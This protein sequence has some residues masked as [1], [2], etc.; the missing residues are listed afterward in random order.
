MKVDDFN[1]AREKL[2][3]AFPFM[4]NTSEAYEIW[5]NSLLD[6][7]YRDVNKAVTDW[8]LEN[9]EPP[10]IAEIRYKTRSAERARLSVIDVHNIETCKC[11]KCQ[12]SGLII[13]IYHT[14]Y[15]VA[16]ICDCQSGRSKYSFFFLSPEAQEQSNQAQWAKGSRIQKPTRCTD[17]FY[18]RNV[19]GIED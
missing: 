10:T 15:E 17:S 6:C 13:H 9:K 14:G 8:V 2:K 16:E 3:G 5:Y 1:K 11:P 18:R 19:L 4:F 12:D 7:D